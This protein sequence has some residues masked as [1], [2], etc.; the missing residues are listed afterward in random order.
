MEQHWIDEV[1]HFWF[2]ELEPRS[3]F[4]SDPRVDARVRERFE[5]T[6]SRV[7]ADASPEAYTTARGCLAAVITLDQFPRNMYRSSPRAF[8]SD[9]LA[10]A[11]SRSAIDRG[12]DRE[13]DVLERQFLYMPWQHCEDAS[14]QARS[15]QLFEQ[16]DDLIALDFARQHKEIIDLFGRFPHRNAVLGRTSTPEELELLKTHAGF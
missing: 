7:R 2:K 12:F 14:A 16:L 15:V 4:T 13:L 3:W 1:I 8:E 6:Y 9:A 10:L 5:P 11:I